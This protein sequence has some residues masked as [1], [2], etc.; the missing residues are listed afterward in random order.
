MRA[1][2]RNTTGTLTGTPSNVISDPVI[3]RAAT[4]QQKSQDV[5][6]AGL[7]TLGLRFPKAK[8]SGSGEDRRSPLRK[9][10]SSTVARGD[11]G[12]T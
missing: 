7:N 8:V 3:E 2:L 5:G 11:M 9:S 10:A 4:Q 12:D 6:S 1:F